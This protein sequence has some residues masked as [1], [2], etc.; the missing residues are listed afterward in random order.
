LESRVL[1]H[2]GGVKEAFQVL[3]EKETKNGN[4]EDEVNRL[5]LLIMISRNM[6]RPQN[7]PGDSFKRIMD[8][9]QKSFAKLA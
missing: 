8:K 3:A 5:V 4:V 6:Y 1:E 7:F 9:P 2:H